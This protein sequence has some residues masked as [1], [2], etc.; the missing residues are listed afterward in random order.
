M[1]DACA[2]VEDMHDDPAFEGIRTDTTDMI[3]VYLN[4]MAAED[5]AIAKWM[6]VQ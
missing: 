3:G 6:W 4:A 5:R 1:T 2:V